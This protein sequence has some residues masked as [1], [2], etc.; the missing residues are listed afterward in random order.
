M[1][2]NKL[3]KAL[4]QIRENHKFKDFAT[5]SDK[6][7]STFLTKDKTLEQAIKHAVDKF[8]DI[9][10]EFPEF[11]EMEEEEALKLVQSNILNF[12]SEETRSPYIP[13][14]SAGPWIITLNGG[15]IYDTGGYGMIG[16]GHNPDFALKA[17]SKRQTMANIMTPNFSQYRLTRNLIKQIR[18]GACPYHKFTFMNAGSEAVSVAARI[19]DAHAKL[20]TDKGAKH[21]GKEIKYLALKGSFHGRTYRAAQASSSSLATYKQLASFR[22]NEKLLTIEPNNIEDLKEKFNSNIYYEMMFLEPVM[23]EGRAGYAITPEFY[24]LARKLS[25]ENDTLLLADSIQAGM[26]CAGAL[27]ILDY[28]GF[29]NSEAP[30]FETFSKALN[31]G[32]YPLS[33]LAMSEYAAKNYKSGLYGNTMTGNPR[34]LDVASEILEHLNPETKA[35]IVKMGEVFTTKLQSL[36]REFPEI[37]TEV[38]G[39]GLLISA[40]LSEKYPVEGHNCIEQKIRRKGI[41]VIHGSGNRLRFTPW[42]LINEQEI[43]LIMDVMRKVFNGRE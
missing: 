37:I 28:P 42:F 19:S 12:Y 7:I 9:T 23:G 25:R 36:Q 16:F 39:T 5:I 27:S 40:K 33:V 13:L 18:A 26:R 10:R 30:D 31:G 11:L 6:Q 29:E 34:A 41:N 8:K 15:V 4:H 24:N 3:L 43:D 21:A 1:F 38:L 20:M 17:L 2:K 14:A 22:D 35:N 32:Q